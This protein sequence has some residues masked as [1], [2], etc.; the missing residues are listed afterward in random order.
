MITQST[1]HRGIGDGI[2]RTAFRNQHSYLKNAYV[3]HFE[4]PEIVGEDEEGQEVPH[5]QA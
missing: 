3:D 4:S 1:P 2:P 5:D